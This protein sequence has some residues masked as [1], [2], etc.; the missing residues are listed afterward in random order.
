MGSATASRRLVDASPA[1][2]AMRA[3]SVQRR[4]VAHLKLDCPPPGRWDATHR[5]AFAEEI[6]RL[7]RLPDVSAIALQ[8]RRLFSDTVRDR[9]D[10][11]PL[12]EVLSAVSDASVP[13]VAL[14]TGP[15]SGSGLELA[16]AC[17]ARIATTGATFADL[18]GG[19]RLPSH[20][21]L[22][23]LIRLMAVE[24]AAQLAVFGATLDARQATELGLVDAMV[25]RNLTAF[26]E[27]FVAR[28]GSR[29]LAPN[30]EPEV[31]AAQL[32]GL[33]VWVRRET[34]Q[35]EAP[36]M[37]LRALECA[38][39]MPPR[40]A[41]PEHQR[42]QDAYARTREA[43][44]LEYAAR[45]EAALRRRTLPADLANEIRWPLLREAIHLLDEGATPAQV[46]REFQRFGFREGPFAEADR[47]GLDA[48]FGRQGQLAG[49]DD[50]I[51][52][53]ATLDLMADAGRLGGKDAPGWYRHGPDGRQ[54]YAP[55]VEQLL[56]ASAT[57]QRL[58]R[59]PLPD[60]LVME[61]CL[62]AAMNGAANVL[63]M[64]PDLSA[65][66]VDAIWVRDMGFPRWRGGP[67][68]MARASREPVDALERWARVRNT[69]G[70]PASLLRRIAGSGGSR[71]PS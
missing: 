52:Y 62:F 68:F 58:S 32:H 45:S 21:A 47:I 1:A 43:H 40:R 60:A 23:R 38:A 14:I 11:A 64:R 30:A 70:A 8:G 27:Q 56:N 57:F 34:P 3:A 41:V 19:A 65:D 18:A 26:A 59:R 53:S 20:A 31:V 55:E 24:N 7:A 61:R 13:V 44:A 22:S 2:G 37:R 71:Q 50:W 5:Q 36:L 28:T 42:I 17:T 33:R 10:D 48:V 16:L 35:Q 66:L 46:D 54:S 15:C 4:Q 67:L 29:P 9:A 12:A 39:L 25:A 6:A 49:N 63:E 69:A 51:T